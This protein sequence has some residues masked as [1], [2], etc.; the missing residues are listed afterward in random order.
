[1]V[2]MSSSVFWVVTWFETD[3]QT[4]LHHITT[5]KTEEVKKTVFDHKHF[6]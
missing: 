3:T 1:M 4:T 6:F 5:Q 2:E